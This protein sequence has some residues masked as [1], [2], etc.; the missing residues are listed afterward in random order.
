MDVF[1]AQVLA[2]SKQS[3]LMKSELTCNWIGSDVNE[4]FNAIPQQQ[5]QK[6]IEHQTLI[7]HGKDCAGYIG[8]RGPS[9][10][11]ISCVGGIPGVSIVNC[12][13]KHLSFYV[14]EAP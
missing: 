12:G 11:A 10:R 8:N 6:T 1:D 2:M 9:L 5:I 3:A 4:A 7:A 13:Y 14:G